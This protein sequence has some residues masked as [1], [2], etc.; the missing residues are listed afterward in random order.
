VVGIS[1]GP[2]IVTAHERSGTL[3]VRCPACFEWHPIERG[4]LGQIITCP[5]PGC[6]TRLRINPFVLESRR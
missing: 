2:I 4:Q 5:S 6:E 1:Y 3:T